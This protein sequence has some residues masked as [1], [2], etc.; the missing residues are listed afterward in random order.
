MLSSGNAIE[1]YKASKGGNGLRIREDLP[2]FVQ[3]GHE[4]LGP[5]DKDLLKW[6]GVFFR[7]PTPGQFM[8]RIRI[9]NGFTNSE[10]LRTVAELSRR[11]GN[12]VLDIT[13]R[14]QLELRGFT[15]ESVPEIWEKLRGVN[16]HSLQTGMDNVRNIN[17]CPLAG[18]TP[19][20]LLDASPVLFELDRIIV[21]SDGN[22]EFTNLPRKFNVTIT[23]C[24]E[25]CTHNESQDIALVPATKGARA[26]FN[27]LVGGKMGSGGFTIAS[28]LDVFVE[29]NDAVM[30]TAE[31]IRLY[32]DHGPRE[33]R[34]KCRLAVLVEQ[35]GLP[36]LRK[37][38]S[39]RLDLELEPAG[40]DARSAHPTDHLGVH[41]QKQTGLIAV[42]LC[43]PTGRI[44]PDQM[45]ELARLAD[46]YGDRQIRLTTGQNAILPNVPEHC[47]EALLGEPLLK[48]LSPA[49]SPLLRGL[50]ACT[51]T[52]YCNLALIE[53]K[54]RAMELS[55]ALEQRLGTQLDPLTIHWSG[56]PAGCG[57]HQA[58]DIGLRGLKANIGG[59]VVDA[60]AIYAGGRTGPHAAAGEQ[61][62]DV[63][64]CDEALPGVLA[65]VI[66]LR[67]RLVRIQ[68]VPAANGFHANGYS[69]NGKA[70]V[71]S[72]A[73]LSRE[74]GRLVKLPDKALALFAFDGRIVATE[75]HCPHAGG[76]LHEGAI[77]GGRIVC[78]WH[79]YGFDLGSGR[80]DAD[81]SLMIR[82]YPA[83]VEQGAVWVSLKES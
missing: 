5:A 42:G 12:S 32:R 54:R 76:P 77:E 20:E 47:L 78:P 57:N 48:Q 10:Q 63:V 52:D 8:M 74:K 56:C 75:A 9:P 3:Q 17:G 40:Q 23:G 31:L 51:G 41:A 30:V 53:T 61:I 50:V 6:V 67:H 37:E 82:T 14:Q 33:A 4:S 43:V 68:A 66:Q 49:P 38:L 1:N 13:T 34:T 79:R 58:A 21:G 28:P 7:R 62:L 16:L 11:L 39:A 15:I 46:T 24:L 80:C 65:T 19:N 22:P 18:L 60:V 72:L 29:P 45:T 44:H 81:P 36:R 64:P 55:Q 59:K 26:G 69:K 35:W 73:E 27:I 70:R 83:F 25:N 2:R 71:C